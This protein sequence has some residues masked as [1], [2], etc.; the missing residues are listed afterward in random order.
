MKHLK[1][2][3][4]FSKIWESSD[5]FTPEEAIEIY[6]ENRWKWDRARNQYY[7]IITGDQFTM[8][9][10]EKYYPNWTIEDFKKVYLAMEGELPEEEDYS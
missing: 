4:S 6:S 10:L 5:T 9:E 8:K 2:F 1:Q 7:E 3:E